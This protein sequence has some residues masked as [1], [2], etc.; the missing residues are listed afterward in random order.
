MKTV[1]WRKELTCSITGETWKSAC[2]KTVE[3]DYKK[4]PGEI[5]V[6]L[7]CNTLKQYNQYIVDNNTIE[8][9]LAY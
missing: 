1:R 3:D 9:L 4:L 7:Y 2:D 8:E 6:P 5:F